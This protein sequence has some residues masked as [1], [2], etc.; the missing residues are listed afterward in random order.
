MKKIIKISITL[1][2]IFISYYIGYYTANSDKNDIVLRYNTRI[3]SLDKK[4]NLLYDSI[5]LLNK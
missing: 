3:D 4:I 2:F 1:L 5:K